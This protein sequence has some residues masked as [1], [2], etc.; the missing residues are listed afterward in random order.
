[1]P[2]SGAAANQP[3]T[4][5]APV[6]TVPSEPLPEAKNSPVAVARPARR[7][8]PAWIAATIAIGVLILGIV[9]NWGGTA[10]KPVDLLKNVDLARDTVAGDWQL[11]NGVLTSP[12]APRARLALPHA[13]PKA[14]KLEIEAQR[15]QGGRLAIGLVRDGRQLPV[16]LDFAEIDSSPSDE[17]A[18]RTQK[19][20][21]KIGFRGGP[22]STYT[23]IV[24]PGGV[25]VAYEDRIE[26]ALLPG[27][28]PE[29][30]LSDW[31][32]P[33]ENTLFVG[34]HHSV[35]HFHKITLTPLQP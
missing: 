22:A 12:D 17:N 35:Y 1:M 5:A 18:V 10:T 16:V 30:P 26:V 13:L 4:E 14:Y 34:T 21:E 32:I 11:K 19:L 29:G 33:Q 20:A 2:G 15:Q 23:A 24:H 9:L 6:E 8:S 3:A 28:A 31:R 25:L 27:E 7:L